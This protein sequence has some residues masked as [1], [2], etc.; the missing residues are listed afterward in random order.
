MIKIK[1][2]LILGAIAGLGGNLIKLSIG[3]AAM[4]MNLAEVGG[5]E[6]AAGM[7][8]PGHKIVTTEGKVVGYI[9]DSVIAGLL[10]VTTVYALS[11][12][13][14]DKAITKGALSGE[15]A[16]TLLYG[17]LTTMG[18]TKVGPVGPKTV[19]SEVVSHTA[20]G[21]I[22]AY[23][24]TKLGDPGLFNGQLPLSAS[25][26]SKAAALEQQQQTAATDPGGSG[27]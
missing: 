22:T 10:G 18:A 6:R 19:L 11:I 2:R 8:V 21:A 13:G 24:V 17:L 7:L 14:K 4:K 15:A 12:T 16:W 3:K 9:A 1:D 27:T 5:P 26:H 20:Y 25:P 23:L